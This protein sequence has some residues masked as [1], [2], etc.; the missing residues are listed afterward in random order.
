[1][2]YKKVALLM[3]ISLAIQHTDLMSNVEQG[4]S[5]YEV[6]FCLPVPMLVTKID[7]PFLEVK[8]SAHLRHSLFPVRHS[9]FKKATHLMSYILSLFC[10]AP[11]LTV[12]GY[13]ACYLLFCVFPG[14]FVSFD[15]IRQLRIC[16]NRVNLHYLANNLWY[17]DKWNAPV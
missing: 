10:I 14:P 6:L 8:F 4:M 17:F 16:D 1:M 13:T 5:N 7:Q 9:I 11:P 12:N 2:Q 15:N 3:I